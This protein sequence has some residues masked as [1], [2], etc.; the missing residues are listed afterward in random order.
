MFG[1]WHWQIE[2]SINYLYRRQSANTTLLSS[3]LNESTA[4]NTISLLAGI[5]IKKVHKLCDI[6]E[7]QTCRIRKNTFI[8][9]VK[10]KYEKCLHDKR[11]AASCF[12]VQLPC[13]CT[14]LKFIGR[15]SKRNVSRWSTFHFDEKI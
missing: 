12:M 2:I 11:K 6:H 5:L 4:I 1:H 7:W 9:Q 10:W 3:S 14:K 8:F 13:S 15:N